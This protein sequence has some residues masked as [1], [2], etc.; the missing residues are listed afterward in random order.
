MFNYGGIY[1]SPKHIIPYVNQSTAYLSTGKS[2]FDT[3]FTSTELLFDIGYFRPDLIFFIVTS[4]S[5][6]LL[7]LLDLLVI[8][9]HFMF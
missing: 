5:R 9:F 6:N 3:T 7:D 2:D 4:S 8:P 1:G